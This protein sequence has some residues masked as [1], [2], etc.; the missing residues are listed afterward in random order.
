MTDLFLTILNMSITASVLVLLILLLRLPLKRMPRWTAVLLWGIVAVRLVCPLSVESVLSLLPETQWV[1]PSQFFEVTEALPQTEELPA[2]LTP[3]GNG[4]TVTEPQVT[5]AEP[6]SPI[7]PMAA[8]AALWAAGTLLMLLYTVASYLR[9]KR[10]VQAA[11]HVGGNIYRSA[12]VPAPFVLGV[13]KPRIYLPAGET[14]ERD[15]PHIIAH[16]TAHIRRGDHLWKPLGF[17]LLAIHWFNP[18]IWA[19][20]IFLCRDIEAACDEKAIKELGADDR[21]DY[22]A[23]LLNCSIRRRT[24][25]ACPLA[26]GEVSV[27]ERVKTVL[28]YKKPTVIAIAAAVVVC[29]AAAVCFLTN[30]PTAIDDELKAF[31]ME[32]VIAYNRSPY[33]AETYPSATG[34]DHGCF[35]DIELLGKSKSGSR[36]TLYTWV[37]YEEYE[38]TDGE[39]VRG[40]GS[41]IPTVIIV[42]ET[43]DGYVLV[44]YQTPGDGKKHAEDIRQMFPWYLWVKALDSTWCIDKQEERLRAE[45]L[46]YFTSV[47]EV[48][49]VDTPPDVTS[50]IDGAVYRADAAVWQNGSYSHT[51]HDCPLHEHHDPK[52]HSVH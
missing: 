2:Q 31:A 46:A 42:E 11:V 1:E 7:S 13:V 26:F 29:L 9:L 40:C 16:E 41:H 22:S 45:A 19:A 12:N 39:P 49:G 48:G 38:F 18:L 37:L 32:Q 6:K 52:R 27:K 35:A 28:N 17:L 23:A 10:M 20:Y 44:D 50:A 3:A 30:P 47:S 15:L 8:C 14:D 36:T 51:V 21:A 33:S 34:G 5:L 25:A 24:V 4:E 43:E